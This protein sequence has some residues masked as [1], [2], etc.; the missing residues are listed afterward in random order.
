MNTN[1]H[2]DKT[3][4]EGSQCICLSVTLV[5]SVFRTGKNYYPQ[6]FLEECKY[7]PKENKMLKCITTD[8]ISKFQRNFF[9]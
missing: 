9:L 2:G 1:F 5:N 4:K 7:V 6:L 3:P 8:I